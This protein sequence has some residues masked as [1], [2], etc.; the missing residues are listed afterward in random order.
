MPQEEELVSEH[1]VRLLS[2]LLAIHGGCRLGGQRERGRAKNGE[3]EDEELKTEGTF[4][5]HFFPK[6]FFFK[7]FLLITKIIFFLKKGP[8]LTAA[9]I[10]T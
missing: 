1:E 4:Q 9:V 3:A 8:N 10:E 2:S 6:H 5:F 7:K